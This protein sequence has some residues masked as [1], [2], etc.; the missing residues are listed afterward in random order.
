MGYAARIEWTPEKDAT[1]RALWPSATRA[2]LRAAFPACGHSALQHRAI[3]LGCARVK[4]DY[5]EGFRERLAARVAAAK[6]RL[7]KVLYPVV[8]RGGV[9][10][11][12]CAACREWKPLDAY[13]KNPKHSTG[14]RNMC[15][16]CDV[17]NHKVR[18]DQDPTIR[19]RAVQQSIKYQLTHPEARRRHKQLYAHK[20]RVREGVGT[21]LTSAEWTQIQARFGGLCAYCKNAPGL[22]MDHVIPLSKG[23]AHAAS[24]VVPACKTCNS[25]KHARTPEEWAAATQK[26]G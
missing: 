6:P 14:L 24:N 25:K 8:V 17:E 1:L 3:R 16:A 12:C 2:E 21:G 11:K 13:A 4:R 15:T 5:P 7:G 10:S 22:T 19:R 9:P 18:R 23:G 26:G 20:R